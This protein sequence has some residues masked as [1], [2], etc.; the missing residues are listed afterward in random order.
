[1]KKYT[2]QQ[3]LAFAEGCMLD[4]LSTKKDTD[5]PEISSYD[6]V[7]IKQTLKKYTSEEKKEELNY[8]FI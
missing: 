7:R 1:M 2:K 6:I 3:M 5:L 4:L 8:L